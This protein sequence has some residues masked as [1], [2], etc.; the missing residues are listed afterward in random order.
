MHRF[1]NYFFTIIG[2]NVTTEHSVELLL[3]PSPLQVEPQ[4]VPRGP[5]PSPVELQLQPRPDTKVAKDGE[6]TTFVLIELMQ[7]FG[8]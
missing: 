4:A 2:T 5:E 1:K 7:Y 6:F 8:F 3:K